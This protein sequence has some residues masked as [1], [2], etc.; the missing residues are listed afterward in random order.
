MLA[1]AR[2]S[3]VVAAI[4][5]AKAIDFSAYVLRSGPVLD[6]LESAARRGSKVSVRLEG[7]PYAG[8]AGSRQAQL[9]QVNAR[10][11]LAIDAAGGKAALV[12]T[13]SRPAAPLHL[14]AAVCDGVAYL[15]ER[16]WPAHGC[17]TI[18]RDAR[19]GDV[20]AIRAALNGGVA[21]PR[22]GFS[23][24][25]SGA[26]AAEARLLR[27]APRGRVE[28]ESESFGRNAAYGALKAL[29]AR[30]VHCRLL[31]CAA[32]L[33][34]RSTAAMTDLQKAGVSVRLSS[35]AEKMALVDGTRAWIGSANATY[36]YADQLDWGVST[37]ARNIVH[38]LQQRFERNWNHSRPFRSS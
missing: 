3:D 37:R 2:A 4:E 8:P 28:V 23:T 29:A 6:A 1:L 15:D 7:R 31:V 27:T 32:D 21:H 5:H 30:G 20:D 38:P 16:N 18:L 17:D 14:K 33:S 24:G 35:C 34:A 11:A 36:G 25:K 26:L 13:P 10:T 19:A 9:A 22:P 12:D